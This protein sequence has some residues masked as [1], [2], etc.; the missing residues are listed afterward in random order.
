MT[1]PTI[2]SFWRSAKLREKLTI[3]IGILYIL[4]PIDFVPEIILGPLGLLDD[5]GALLAVV[6]TAMGILNRQRTIRRDVIDGEEIN[7]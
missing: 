7:K 5:G 4:L 3:I 2:S 1:E 6:Y